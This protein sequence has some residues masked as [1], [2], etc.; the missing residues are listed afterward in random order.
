MFVK[1]RKKNFRD[2]LRKIG[3][4]VVIMLILIIG[5]R[6]SAF[7]VLQ[8]VG[9]E[10]TFDQHVSELGLS[11]Q[12]MLYQLDQMVVRLKFTYANLVWLP[13][14]NVQT[15]QSKLQKLQQKMAFLWRNTF[16]TNTTSNHQQNFN[17]TKLGIKELPTRNSLHS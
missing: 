5:H 16:S 17:Q 6:R 3:N 11:I 13:K 7:N 2:F 10:V 8:G 12:K 15:V 4:N 14:I 9:F 1:Q